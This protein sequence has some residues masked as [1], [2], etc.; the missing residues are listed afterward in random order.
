MNRSYLTLQFAEVGDV[1]RI[2]PNNYILVIGKK[3]RESKNSNDFYYTPCNFDGSLTEK[4]YIQSAANY[5]HN[6]IMLAISPDKFPNI[7]LIN[8]VE[9]KKY[10]VFH[11]CKKYVWHLT[12][13]SEINDHMSHLDDRYTLFSDAASS[14]FQREYDRNEDRNFHSENGSMVA[15]FCGKLLV[16]KI[17]KAKGL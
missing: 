5:I 11:N 13:D 17:L 8:R 1:L 12:D 9:L 15:A 3:S 4:K 14:E 10:T 16:S 2:S 7:E 6:S